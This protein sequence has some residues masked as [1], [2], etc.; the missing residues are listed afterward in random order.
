MTNQAETAQEK[1]IPQD[2][3]HHIQNEKVQSCLREFR[4]QFWDK[5]HVN[6]DYWRTEWK[7]LKGY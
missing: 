6:A 1:N 2:P 7:E 5:V 4:D 3:K